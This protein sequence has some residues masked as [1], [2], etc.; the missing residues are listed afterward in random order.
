MARGTIYEVVAEDELN[1]DISLFSLKEEDLYQHAGC[2]F[3]WCGDRDEDERKIDI[4]SL[5][6]ILGTGFQTG[7]DPITI[8]TIC[9]DDGTTWSVAEVPYIVVTEEAKEAYFKKAFEQMKE[10]VAKLTLK[11]F[12][13]D[14]YDLRELI[15]DSYGDAACL[16]GVY[17]WSFDNFVRALT[18]GKKYYI[19]NTIYMH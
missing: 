11:E 9:N 1:N 15:A 14:T 16:N 8:D 5:F 3:D 6:T 19:G 18:P 10:K 2:E 7:T 17:Y 13:T 12:A 4:E